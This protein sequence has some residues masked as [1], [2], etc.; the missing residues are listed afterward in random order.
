MLKIIAG[1]FMVASS[2]WS[3]GDPSRLTLK[4]RKQANENAKARA[5]VQTCER[6]KRAVR[7]IISAH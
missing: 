3:I 1:M 7:A 6:A 4:K 2:C 5:G